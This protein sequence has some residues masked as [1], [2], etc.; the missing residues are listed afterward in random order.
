MFPELTNEHEYLNDKDFEAIRERVLKGQLQHSLVAYDK[1]DAY[2]PNQKEF[3]P[4]A[5]ERWCPCLI[6]DAMLKEGGHSQ[7]DIDTAR[8]EA[9]KCTEVSAEWHDC[10]L[11]AQSGDGDS[12]SSD[13]E[14]DPLADMCATP[15]GYGRAVHEKQRPQGY[16]GKH[17]DITAIVYSK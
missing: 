6:Q 13:Y 9:E 1:C 8:Q 3:C 17:A 14:D 5:T 11:A 15:T 12:V 16:L 10:N 2:H 7:A 4:D